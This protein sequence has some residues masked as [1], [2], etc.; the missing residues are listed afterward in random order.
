MDSLQGRKKEKIICPIIAVWVVLILKISVNL[1]LGIYGYF[2]S[3]LY[4]IYI[5]IDFIASLVASIF[6]TKSFELN[7]YCFYKTGLFII[8]GFAIPMTVIISSS[9]YG[10]FSILIALV[11]WSQFIVLII[12]NNKIK[13]YFSDGDL[14]NNLFHGL[15]R[16]VP[17]QL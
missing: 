2:Y 14:N 1:R 17:P 16:E 15:P 13:Q 11:E 3:Q 5:I 7:K 4:N 12:Y 9:G 10:F 6:V 8:L